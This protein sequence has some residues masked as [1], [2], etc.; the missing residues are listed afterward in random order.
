M[1]NT[2]QS[3]AYCAYNS[4]QWIQ[5]TQQFETYHMRCDGGIGDGSTIAVF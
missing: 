2:F 5:N 4:L 1:N 3:L